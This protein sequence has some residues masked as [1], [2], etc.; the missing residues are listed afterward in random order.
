MDLER[1]RRIILPEKKA[2]I[3][4]P[5]TLR[6][7]NLEANEKEKIERT[8]KDAE[9]LVKIIKNYLEMI[10]FCDEKKIKPS[11][12]FTFDNLRR[13]NN[14]AGPD[15]DLSKLTSMFEQG[16]VQLARNIHVDDKDDLEKRLES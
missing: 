2:G 14:P 6:V 13:P 8:L 3:T 10:K 11:Y 9:H 12:R 4:P 5:D 1:P 16:C 15:S 7:E